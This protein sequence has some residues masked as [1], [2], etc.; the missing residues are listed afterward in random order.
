MYLEIW[1]L[2]YRFC[3][4]KLYLDVIAPVTCLGIIR[5]GDLNCLA[6]GFGDQRPEIDIYRT[7]DWSKYGCNL[8]H[9]RRITKILQVN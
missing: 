8:A 6:I 3:M 1:D 4:K 2:E 9:T 7:D 5:L